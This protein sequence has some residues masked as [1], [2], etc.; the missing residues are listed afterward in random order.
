MLYLLIQGPLQ[1]W[2]VFHQV[3][4]KG[5]QHPEAGFALFAGL[6]PHG[7]LLS[8]HGYLPSG[9]VPLAKLCMDLLRINCTLRLLACRGH[10]FILKHP[11]SRTDP[12]RFRK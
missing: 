8:P 1:I 3:S 7:H 12:G 5:C 11:S 9:T 10:L 6:S 4:G 2:D